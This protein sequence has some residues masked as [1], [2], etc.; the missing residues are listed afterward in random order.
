M[1]LVEFELCSSRD[2][3]NFELPTQSKVATV[4]KS[5]SALDFK[6]KFVFGVNADS[7]IWNYL[8]LLSY[9]CQQWRDDDD[10]I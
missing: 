4:L 9:D 6:S 7:Y 1:G 10:A 3:F 2:D 8:R 5:G